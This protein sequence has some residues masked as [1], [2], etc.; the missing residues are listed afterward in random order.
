VQ[1]TDYYSVLLRAIEPLDRSDPRARSELYERARRMLIE[2]IEKDRSRWTRAAAA[3]E[4]DRFDDAVDR[5]EAEIAQRAMRGAKERFPPV[6]A[7]DYRT[8]EDLGP[9]PTRRG[10][11]LALWSG[12][13]LAVVLLFGLIGYALQ[14][15][16]DAPGKRSAGIAAPDTSRAVFDTGELEPGVDGGS[17]DAGLPYYLRRQAVYYRSV[18]TDGMIVIDRSQRF[19][20]LVQPQ[21]RAL[22]YGIGVGGEC[23]VGA[24]LYRIQRKAEWPKWS[25]SP[26]LLKRRSYPAV[27]QGGPGNPLGAYAMYFEND[28]PAI[29]GTNAPKSIGQALSIGCFRLINNDVVDL[30]KRAP[31]GTGIVVSN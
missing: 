5:I 9:L 31:I 18:Y 16:Q 17:T 19:L 24:G 1:L 30:E 6:P 13:G 26:A 22:R 15:S 28:S 23:A 27:V 21:S 7:Q 11:R 20:Y 14:P 2:T 3:A 10:H 4:L 25:P 12:I 29:H 8:D